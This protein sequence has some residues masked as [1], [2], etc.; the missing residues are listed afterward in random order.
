MIWNEQYECMPVE[1]L[2][3]LQFKRLRET[4][5]RVYHKVPYYRK[6][7]DA[8][9]VK[10]ADIQKLGDLTK[11]PFMIKKDLRDNYPYGLFTVPLREIV[12]LQASSGTTGKPTVVGYTKGDLE[13]W[14]ELMARSLVS[15]GADHDA[16]VQNA[17]SYGLFTGGLGVHYGA[18]RIGASIIPISVGKTK[19]QVMMMQEF[20]AT[21]LASTPSYA[22]HLA[23]AMEEMDIDQGSLA[24]K[25]GVF[26]AEP[27]SDNMRREIE[28]N[29]GIKAYDL[30]GLS[31]I[32]GPG[33]SCE[34]EVQNGLHIN[35]DHFIAEIIDPLTGEVLPAGQYG[36]LVLT[37]LTKEAV[38][39][40]RYRSRDISMLLEDS[41]PC[42]RTH[43]RMARVTG[44]SDD[45]LI[46]RGIN[47]FP[48]QIESVLLEIAEIEPHYLLV[49]DRVGNLDTLEVMVEISDKMFSDE[50]KKLDQMEKRINRALESSLGIA[51][52]VRL[53]EPK[54]IERS[55]TK[56]KRVVDLRKF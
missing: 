16:L 5:E 45:M 28:H 56:A 18:E 20:G 8:L 29:L 14:S 12:R 32:M 53:V 38:P 24:L 37:T 44:R 35:E 26:G 9:K 23:E 1:E 21:M 49:V 39:L 10:P 7:M 41:C 13:R 51:V 33:V 42:G 30:Y 15:A 31:E 27:W 47:V 40:I 48:S 3:A 55:E 52:K 43:L 6:K 22:L 34:C 17:F 50:M 2:K 11:L 54:T 19:R 36:E 25:T 46:I 4:V